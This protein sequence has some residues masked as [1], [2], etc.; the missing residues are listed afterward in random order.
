MTRATTAPRVKMSAIQSLVRLVNTV[1]GEVL[2]HR[3]AQQGHLLKVKHQLIVLCA[4]KAITVC[5][6]LLFQVCLHLFFK[7]LKC[8]NNMHIVVKIGEIYILSM[9]MLDSPFHLPFFR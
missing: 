4:P 3:T 8:F 2:S 9:A 7:A 1:P 6:N 5:Q